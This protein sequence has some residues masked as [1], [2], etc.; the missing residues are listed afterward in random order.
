VNRINQSNLIQSIELMSS[1]VFECFISQTHCIV[2][3]VYKNTYKQNRNIVTEVNSWT[4]EGINIL[5]LIHNNIP[6]LLTE[7][8]NQST[9]VRKILM[10]LILILITLS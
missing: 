6:T 5:L 1:Q 9:H 10:I 7:N 3:I 2:M 4:Q 8:L